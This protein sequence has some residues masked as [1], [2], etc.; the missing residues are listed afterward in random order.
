MD[1]KNGPV[2]IDNNDLNRTNHDH[3]VLDIKNGSIIDPNFLQF[4][5]KVKFRAVRRGNYKTTLSPGRYR[6]RTPR[7]YSTSGTSA[8]SA[9]ASS[10]SESSA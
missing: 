9:H 8:S 6:Q 1:L 5:L 4:K 10:T 3:T 2:Q 7:R